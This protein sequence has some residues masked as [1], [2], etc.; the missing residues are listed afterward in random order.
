[1]LSCTKCGIEYDDGKKYCKKCG[2]P[3]VPKERPLQP[4]EEIQQSGE[5]EQKQKLICPTCNLAY[6]SGKFC[7]K[8]G[9]ALVTQAPLQDNKQTEKVSQPVPKGDTLSSVIPEKQPAKMPQEKLI[10]PNCRSIFE[11]GKFCKKCGTNLGPQS[12][13]PEKKEILKVYLS[14]EKKE[15][16]E[17]QLLDHK[18]VKKKGKEWLKLNEEKRKLNLL[19]KN[20]QLQHGKVSSDIFNVTFEKYQTQY[21][22]VSSRYQEIEKEFGFVRIN[23]S[24]RID[25]L[26]QELKPIRKRL[27]E[28][29]SLYKLGAI[30]KSDFKVERNTLK[31]EI[32]L[33]ESD[34]KRNRKMIS[35]LPGKMGGV[36]DTRG[37][38]GNLLRPIPIAAGLVTLILA[39]AGYLL[40][41][42]YSYLVKKQTSSDMSTAAKTMSSPSPFAPQGQP[43][44]P[45]GPG[46]QETELIKALLENIKQANLQKNIELFMSCYSQDF[47]DREGKRL[48]TL[49]KWKNLDYKDLSW[50]LESQ[51]IISG[52]TA[53]IKVEWFL[54]TSLKT[55]VESEESKS[56]L[57]VMLVKEGGG[58]R[59]KEARI[60]EELIKTTLQQPKAETF[61]LNP[62]GPFV[63]NLSDPGRYLKIA[64]DFELKDAKYEPKFKGHIGQLRDMI[65]SS[66][67][68][69]RAELLSSPDGKKRLKDELVQKANQII[70]EPIVKTI[71][72]TDFVMQ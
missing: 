43:S 60:T 51:P 16:P 66:L 53:T 21:E 35:L 7:K 19:I 54:I 14:E 56:I 42:K 23:T 29:Q 25:L 47:T 68:S 9:T 48:A 24:G 11:S 3:L 62:F 4:G 37:K 69:K 27:A 46:N 70:G 30:A 41:P 32:N 65:I 55:K 39:V 52:N 22:S 1:M 20:L 58:W 72:F 8:C 15:I 67:S 71:Y 50:N 44:L 38:A 45:P 63:V 5:K 6:E 28:V 31:K 18:S 2:S 12:L 17:S 26:N 33:R 49:E 34:L 61:I 36:L 59:I 10:C 13:H 57:D 40:W 64:I